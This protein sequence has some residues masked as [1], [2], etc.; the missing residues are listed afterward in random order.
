[1]FRTSLLAAAMTVG[2]LSAASAAMIDYKA[3][4]NGKS[5]VPPTLR[6]PAAATWWPR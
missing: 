5:E 2:F 6:L 1:M 3:T 4:M